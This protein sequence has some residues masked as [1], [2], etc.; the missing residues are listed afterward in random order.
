MVNTIE[1]FKSLVSAKGG[2]A[3]TN[4]FQVLL[5]PIPGS[6]ITATEMDIICS[7]VTLPG[8]QVQTVDRLI[9]TVS[10]K[11]A[12]GSITDDVSFTFNV[13]NDYGIKKYFDNWQKI[14]YNPDTREIGYKI[15]YR[16]QVTINQL[17]KGVGSQIIYEC[18]L[19][20]AWPINMDTVTLNND[21]DGLVEITVQLAY[22][23]WSSRYFN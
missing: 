4:M 23:R 16:Q 11:V 18:K 14:A 10:E 22:T 6:N 17:K 1:E 15:D 12:T 20:E 9:G 13:L 8:R 5:P 3:Q 2:F 21:L 7:S 19:L